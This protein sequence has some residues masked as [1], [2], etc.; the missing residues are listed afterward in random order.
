LPPSILRL[1]NRAFGGVIL[2]TRSNAFILST[3]VLFSIPALA[4][5][6]GGIPLQATAA[7]SVPAP[8]ATPAKR[9]NK[10]PKLSTQI[11]DLARA[12]PQ[13]TAPM[14]HNETVPGFSVEALPKSIQDATKAGVMKINAN[15]QVQVYIELTTLDAQKLNELRTYGVTVQIIGK[16][17]PDKTKGE[18][19]TSVPTVQALLPVVMIN[20]V[21]ALPYVRYIRLPD[22]GMKSTGSVNSQGDQILQVAQARSQFG[23]DG[24]GVRIG[25]ISDGIGVD[26]Q[27]FPETDRPAGS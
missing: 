7:T 21:A 25:V 4:Q 27:A 18:V 20:Q 17:I 22:Y 8:A 5:Q 12:L 6:Q 14:A 24:T 1:E 16:P 9:H 15:G 23:V 2:V 19:L 13:R 10:H 11:A 3:I 26:D